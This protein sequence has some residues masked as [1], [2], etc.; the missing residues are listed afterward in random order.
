[1]DALAGGVTVAPDDDG[2]PCLRPGE[3]VSVAL[4]WELPTETPQTVQGDSVRFD[5][6]FQ[7][8]RCEGGGD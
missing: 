4:G 3:S 5:L 6:A 2:R 1:V 7:A 8:E